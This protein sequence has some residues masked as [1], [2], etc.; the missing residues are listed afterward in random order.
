VLLL[1]FC[2]S[3]EETIYAGTA[4]RKKD[5]AAIHYSILKERERFTKED[6]IRKRELANIEN[7]EI[8]KMQVNCSL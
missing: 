3:S 7:L 8:F 2:I 5:L 4:K 6:A 1:V